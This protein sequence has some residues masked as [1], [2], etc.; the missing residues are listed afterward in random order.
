MRRVREL[1]GDGEAESALSVRSEG[2]AGSDARAFD[3]DLL[4]ARDALEGAV[5]AGR[6]AGGEEQF[7]VPPVASASAV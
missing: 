1:L 6:V 4:G 7:G 2:D 3:R 5:E